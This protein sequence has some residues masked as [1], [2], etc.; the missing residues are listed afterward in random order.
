MLAV[1]PASHGP[2]NVYVGGLPPSVTSDV[3]HAAFVPFG[4]LT[5]VYVAV[6]AATGQPRGFAF[7][8]FVEMADACAAIDNMHCNIMH[9]SRIDVKLAKERR[10]KRGAGKALWHEPEN[11]D[12]AGAGI[13]GLEMDVLD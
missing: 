8:G 5:D 11:D 9:G 12:T 3:L 10:A 7:V 4:E 13:A 2:A 1:P 6:N